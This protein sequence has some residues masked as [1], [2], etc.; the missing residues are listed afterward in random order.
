MKFSNTLTTSLWWTMDMVFVDITSIFHQNHIA[1]VEP[2]VMEGN[3]QHQI[4]GRTSE[5]FCLINSM[6]TKLSLLFHSQYIV[7]VLFKGKVDHRAMLNNKDNTELGS[8]A[9]VILLSHIYIL[10]TS[11]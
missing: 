8:H 7:N 11:G 6:T 9:L 5:Y 4:K 3:I 10:P 2:S 1:Q